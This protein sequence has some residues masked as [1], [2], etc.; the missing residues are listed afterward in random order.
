MCCIGRSSAEAKFRSL[1]HG[2]CEAIRIKRLLKDLKL[3]FSSPMKVYCDNKASSF[4]TH[5]TV[6]SYQT[7]HLKVKKHSLSNKRLKLD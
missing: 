7:K 1:A 6:H 5:N 2:I 3:P 4:I